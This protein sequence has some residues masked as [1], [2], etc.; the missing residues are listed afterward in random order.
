MFHRF[1]VIIIIVGLKFSH[2]IS[3]DNTQPRKDIHGQFMD[4]HFIDIPFSSQD[5]LPLSHC[6]KFAK[7]QKFRNFAK[8]NHLP[9]RY[10]P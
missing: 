10:V 8:K 6:Y 4:I 7:A 9:T 3:I 2:A 5:P 1:Y